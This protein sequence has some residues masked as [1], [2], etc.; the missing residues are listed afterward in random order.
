QGNDANNLTLDIAGGNFGVKGE[1]TATIKVDGDGEY[2][3][4]QL[5]PGQ[6]YDIATF[7]VALNGGGTAQVVLKGIGGVPDRCFGKTTKE[8]VGY[9]ADVKEHEF[10][11]VPVEG[12]DGRIW[13]NNNLGAEYARVGSPVYNPLKQASSRIDTYA[14]GSLFQW[15]RKPDG[16]ELMHVTDKKYWYLYEYR[17]IPWKDRG[18]YYNPCPEGWRLPTAS[19]WE[20]LYASSGLGVHVLKE[21]TVA[22][23]FIPVGSWGEGDGH[24]YFMGTHQNYWLSDGW[25]Q[26]RT[27]NTGT[28]D[29]SPDVLVEKKNI[30]WSLPVRC[31]KDN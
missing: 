8:C 21:P 20:N 3:V 19:E 5:A 11:Y 29:Y 9:G 10:L 13:L 31:I 24:L 15:G 28:W 27:A 1:L 30:G 22:P 18:I 14:R 4:K 26:S 23:L 6:S 2:L 12:P 17:S 25:R 7:N 16:H